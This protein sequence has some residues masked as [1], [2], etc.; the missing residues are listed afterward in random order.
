MRAEIERIPDGEY[1]FEDAIEDDGISEGDYPM[2][3]A[4]DRATAAR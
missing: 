1:S 3:L 4:A 2:K